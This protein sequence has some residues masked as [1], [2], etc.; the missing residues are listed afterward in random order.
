MNEDIFK[1]SNPSDIDKA[2][3]REIAQ[4]EFLLAELLGEKREQTIRPIGNIKSD[5]RT[6]EQRAKSA[7]RKEKNKARRSKRNKKTS[8]PKHG[9]QSG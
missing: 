7:A 2:V 6:A 4:K 5:G 3:A 8:R 1:Y 9:R